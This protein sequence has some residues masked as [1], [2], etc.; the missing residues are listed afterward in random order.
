M[1][2]GGNAKRVAQLLGKEVGAL[3][4]EVR[5]ISSASSGAAGKG[6][7]K[8]LQAAADHAAVQ[9]GAAQQARAASQVAVKTATS[10]PSMIKVVVPEVKTDLYGAIS[11]VSPNEQVQPGVYKNIDGHRFDDGRYKAFQE[12]LL[13]FIPKERMFSDPV[14]TFAYGT[15]ASFYRLNPRLVSEHLTIPLSGW[16]FATLP[17]GPHAPPVARGTPASAPALLHAIRTLRRG[18]GGG[19]APLLHARAR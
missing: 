16:P 18:L 3:L 1:T 19:P 2:K 12:E 6:G 5:G 9:A 15:D 8:G 7:S 4:S 17:P 14:R 10:A 11:A 13:K